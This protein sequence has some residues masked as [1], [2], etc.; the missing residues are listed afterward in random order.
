MAALTQGVIMSDSAKEETIRKQAI[1]D[2][3]SPRRQKQILKRGFEKWDPFQEPKDPIDIRQDKTKRTSQM[4]I[5]EFLQSLDSESYSNDYAKGAF[6]LCLGIINENEKYA[7]MFDF[8][9]W[10]RELLIAEG[11]R[12]K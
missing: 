7:G 9:C 12:N 11:Q 5:R 10:Y 2:S 8:A 3:M 4:L 6:E 1:F